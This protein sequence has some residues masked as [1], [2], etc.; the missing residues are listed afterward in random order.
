VAERFGVKNTLESFDKRGRVVEHIHGA[1]G[2]VG[3]DATISERTANYNV[4]ISP[5]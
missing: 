3:A 4:V 1:V 2:R 5:L